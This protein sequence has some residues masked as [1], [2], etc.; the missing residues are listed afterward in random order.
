MATG[1][2]KSRFVWVY[3]WP[4]AGKTFNDKPD[5]T[6]YIVYQV[7]KKNKWERVGSNSEGYS[8][9]MAYQIRAERM[10]AI[11]TGVVK[12]PVKEMTFTEA[13]DVAYERHFSKLTMKNE[14]K[15]FSNKYRFSY[16]GDKVLSSVQA[17]D[18]EE[19][20]DCLSKL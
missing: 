20:M 10:K 9:A 6:W 12:A 15:S 5:L 8:A 18:I 14:Y 2:H 17:T 13:F 1:F 11:Q 4:A 7:N 19:L 3:Y 16:F